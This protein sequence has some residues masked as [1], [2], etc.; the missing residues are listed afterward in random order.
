MSEH[1]M[2]KGEEKA[3]T[4]LDTLDPAEVCRKALVSFDRSTGLYTVRSFGM[5]FTVLP[6][7][8]EVRCGNP[9][10][11]L[12][13]TRLRDFFRLSLAWH[14]VSAAEIAPSGSLIRIEDMKDG[15]GFA[16]GS[17]TLPLSRLASLHG[18]NTE[19]FLKKAGAW[20]GT[21]FTLGNAS[22]RLEPFPRI[23]VIVIIWSPDEE[24]SARASLL[25]DS[26]SAYQAPIDVIWMVAMMSILI[27]M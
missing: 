2:S 8:Q 10:G 1:A 4:I 24:F 6:R 25:F 17:H 13:L 11:E 18:T 27:L 5:D 3:W 22:V 12:L 14:L 23:P 7:A 26:T 9:Q 16:T 21:A 15:R 19:A 20:G